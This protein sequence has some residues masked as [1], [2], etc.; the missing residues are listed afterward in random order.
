LHPVHGVVKSAKIA[1]RNLS[2][3]LIDKFPL[4]FAGFRFDNSSVDIRFFRWG[5][6]HLDL[7]VV[8]VQVTDENVVG[9]DDR[10]AKTGNGVRIEHDFETQ[11][12]LELEKRLPIP[13]E[14][15]C[16]LF[17]LFLW[18]LPSCLR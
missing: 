13:A 1:N 16:F 3:L 12:G 11:T 14:F 7:V 10:T 4:L 18:L 5:I 8:V 9:F 17:F 2:P 15:D 6:Q